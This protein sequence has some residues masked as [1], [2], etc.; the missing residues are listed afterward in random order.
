M[1]FVP[2]PSQRSCHRHR[3]RQRRTPRQTDS[4]ASRLGCLLSDLVIFKVKELFWN[5]SHCGSL[6]SKQVSTLQHKVREKDKEKERE[7]AADR[8]ISSPMGAFN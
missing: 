1:L 5:V 2:V 3:R 4:K 7:T 8:E 6:D